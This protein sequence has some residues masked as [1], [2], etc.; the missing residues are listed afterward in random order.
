LAK[1]YLKEA[2]LNLRILSFCLLIAFLI[3]GS[4]LSQDPPKQ[5]PSIKNMSMADL[6]ELSLKELDEANANLTSVFNKL[7]SN[8]DNDDQ[9]NK[10]QAS[11]TAWLNYR[12]VNTDFED[13]FREGGSSQRLN[14]V[15][16]LIRMTKNRIKELQSMIDDNPWLKK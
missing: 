3:H 6:Y 2:A 15:G 14:H 1:N 11:Q 16:C 5:N 4:A 9:K 13:S 7:L 12:D 10:L 8:L